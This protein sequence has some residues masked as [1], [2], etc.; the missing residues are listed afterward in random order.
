MTPRSLFNIILKVIGIF[1]IKNLLIELANILPALVQFTSHEPDYGSF[2]LM[3]LVIVLL[4]CLVYLFITYL[5]LFKANWIINK[6]KLDQGFHQHEFNLNIHR[7]T[8]LRIAIIV[9]G[10]L[11]IVDSLPLLV[12]QLIYYI[13]MKKENVPNIKIDYVVLHTAKLLIG[14]FLVAYQRTLVNLIEYKQRTNKSFNQNPRY[15]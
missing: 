10:S 6:L 9:V 8:I 14:I 11:I 5:L 2:N 3:S 7:S 12:Q 13:R 1:F 15:P 4:E